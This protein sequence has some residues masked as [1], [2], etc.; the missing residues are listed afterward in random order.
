MSQTNEHLSPVVKGLDARKMMIERARK[1][2]HIYGQGAWHDDAFIIGDTKAL[3]MLRDAIDEALSE[4][5]ISTTEDVFVSDGEGYS[6]RVMCC[7]I[8]TFWDILQV[9]YTDDIARDKRESVL[10]PYAI[11]EQVKHG[12]S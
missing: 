8:E 7:N 10:T 3:L 4:S 12:L 11:K 1:N 5:A 2:L 6:V 9:P